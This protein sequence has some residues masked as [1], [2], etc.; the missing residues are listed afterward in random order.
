MDVTQS[1]KACR[2]K[3]RTFN[4]LAR[5]FDVDENNHSLD[6][7]A[8]TKETWTEQLNE[9]LGELV[10][11]AED[12]IDEHRDALGS[13]EVLAWQSSI[14]KAEKVFSLTIG[15]FDRPNPNGNQLPSLASLPPVQ[16]NHQ[17]QAERAAQ[18]NI[19][20]DADIVEKA[21]QV[22]SKE[23]RKFH[24]SD[25][26]TDE[27]IEAEVMDQRPFGNDNIIQSGSCDKDVAE[28]RTLVTEE[29]K[30]V[31]DKTPEDFG[32]NVFDD[33]VPEKFE[34]DGTSMEFDDNDKDAIEEPKL[35]SKCSMSFHKLFDPDPDNRVLKKRENNVTIRQVIRSKDTVRRAMVA[36]YNCDEN[37]AKLADK[38]LRSFGR[39]F[40]VEDN[41]FAHDVAKMG[42]NLPSKVGTDTDSK[43][44]KLPNTFV[45]E[46]DELSD[47]ITRHEAKAKFNP[48][49][50]RMFKIRHESYI[51]MTAWSC[52]RRL[53]PQ[54]QVKIHLTD[55]YA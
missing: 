27:E 19:D 45:A 21:S 54:F 41:Y 13:G 4:Q 23:I 33:I 8:R 24:D 10:E 51:F 3:E 20:I 34:D 29:V 14:K 50:V 11:A 47:V 26:A 5:R 9:A 55:I 44:L 42:V 16:S 39:I 36:F 1:Q 30:D 38:A 46:K 48:D 40:N 12:M 22:L 49:F 31:F 43:Q 53:V 32:K 17:A 18:V 52:F 6:T 2:K 7:V 28:D 25:E 37:H 35:Q 15:K